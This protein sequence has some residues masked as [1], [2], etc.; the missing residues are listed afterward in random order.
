M[1]P[2]SLNKEETHAG[3][4]VSLEHLALP[5]WIVEVPSYKIRFANKASETLYGYSPAELSSLGLFQL[6]EGAGTTRL[7]N[8][9]ASERP[10]EELCHVTAKDGRKLTVRFHF[11]PVR[12]E[13]A[14]CWQIISVDL[15]AVT[16]AMRDME[17][18]KQ[19]Y[20]SYIDQSFEGIYCQELHNPVPVTISPEEMIEAL[21]N[22]CYIAECNDTMAA[23]YGYTHAHELLGV[24][25]AQLLDMSDP[26][27]IEFV[28]GFI[29]NGFKFTGAESHEKDRYGN[30]RYFLNNAIGIVEDG[31]LKRIWGTQTDITGKKQAENKIRFLASLVEQTSDVLTASDLDYKPITWNSAAEKIYGLKA[32]EVIGKDL[33]EL[34][35]INYSG[36][37]R[38]EVR[39]AIAR[40]GEW[41][42]EMYFTRPADQK[43]V[44]VLITFRLLRDEQGQPLGYVI[45]ATDIT[46]RKASELRLMESESRFRDIA[47]SAPVMIWICNEKNRLTYVN[48][49]LVE[50]TGFEPDEKGEKT[51]SGLLHPE[52]SPSAQKKF[53]HHFNL[54]QPVVLSYRLKHVDGS[55]RW[56]QETGIP[57]YLTDGTFIGYIGSVI[58]I[59]DHKIKETQLRYQA[60]ILENV[61]DIIITTDLQY[62]VLSWN[63]VAEKLYNI[64]AA[65]ALNRPVGTIVQLDFAQGSSQD[66]IEGLKKT[67]QWSGEVSHTANGRTR[68][69]HYTGQYN[70]GSDGME[71]GILIVGRDITQTKQAEQKLLSSE[72]FYRALIADS[73]DGMVLTDE[74]GIIRFGSPSVKSVLGYE[75]DEIIRKNIF[76]YVHPEDMQWAA[77][78][79]QQELDLTSPVKFMVVRLKKKTGEW[80]W[81]LVR[82]NNLLG[83][84]YVR[85]MVIYFHDDT[86]RRKASEALKESEKRFRSLI[87]DLKTGVMLQDAEG[88]VQMSNGAVT[89]LFR[90]SEEHLLNNRFWELFPDAIHEDGRPFTLDERPS[91]LALKTRQMVKD[92]VMGI[93]IPGTEER[94]WIIFTANPICDDEGNLINIVCSFTDI[95]ERKKLEHEL[96]TKRI[97]YQRQLTQAT[98][99]A[100]ENE[101][102]EIGKELHDNIGQQLTTV[103][104]FLDMA[105]ETAS[106]KTQNLVNMAQ[107]S[108]LD[109]INEVRAMSRSLVPSTLHDIGLI[110]SLQEHIDSIRRSYPVEIEFAHSG[111]EE[112]K[113]PEKEKIALFRITQEQL[114]QVTR[115][116]LARKVQISLIANEGGFLLEIRDDGSGCERRTHRENSGLTN[117]RNRA[118]LLGGT[119]ELL[120]Q[121]EGLCLLRVWLP[122]QSAS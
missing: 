104:L 100:Q 40:D 85:S 98:I 69:L 93:L 47:D 35:D 114:N 78:S 86:P 16:M 1:L 84:P 42:G 60:N 28:H 59:H 27:N 55:Y 8:H 99:D 115:Q 97:T 54:R 76:E 53:E 22:D 73:L 3:P 48:K 64:P 17:E 10:G 5:V 29:S 24:G 66:A 7:V 58:D 105:N 56:V 61:S 32:E 33:R 75:P 21:K 72:Q 23:M 43:K 52:D 74:A 67:G 50:S 25:A 88:R 113:T 87:R 63:R 94:V 20:K 30:D 117:I 18:E 4:A 101:R 122:L 71:T 31:H 65:E 2:Q 57:R 15:T 11:S 81:T 90:C 92:L 68:F 106:E 102:T 95:T 109:V 41:R 110:D 96:I 49:T 79:F 111:F 19:R 12:S 77:S 13:G 121:K 83:N 108:V 116:A 9:F 80:Q 46:E 62:R 14:S 70:Y 82:G 34:I 120:C 36:A 103:K 112:E 38:E 89:S 119:A 44:I 37:T 45:C 107:R 6:L 39:N 118:E 91:V 51:W 26:A